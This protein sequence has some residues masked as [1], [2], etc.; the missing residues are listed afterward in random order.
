MTLLPFHA[1]KAI[2]RCRGPDMT[3]VAKPTICSWIEEKASVIERQFPWECDASL[4]QKHL[5]SVLNQVAAMAMQRFNFRPVKVL[6]IPPFRGMGKISVTFVNPP[7]YTKR[8]VT[9]SAQRAQDAPPPDMPILA[10]PDNTNVSFSVVGKDLGDNLILAGARGWERRSDGTWGET[11]REM[12][13]SLPEAKRADQRR[14]NAFASDAFT[15]ERPRTVIDQNQRPSAPA[16]P[17]LPPPPPPKPEPMLD[18]GPAQESAKKRDEG[19]A[20]RAASLELD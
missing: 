4:V 15:E 9:I 7:D 5:T 16:S 8:E 14:N 18:L 17:S 11:M 19:I 10:I 6:P 2:K 13:G 1:L 20:A 3:E 12:V